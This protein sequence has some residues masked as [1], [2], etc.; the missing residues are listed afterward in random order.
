[1]KTRDVI[2]FE[3]VDYENEEGRHS[4]NFGQDGV[5]GNVG[6]VEA[7]N[8]RDQ[9]S[10]TR[11]EAQADESAISSLSTDT[12]ES[13]IYHPKYHGGEKSWDD[14]H[15]HGDLVYLVGKER[16]ERSHEEVSFSN[17]DAP[18]GPLAD[19]DG[20]D[21]IKEWRVGGSLQLRLA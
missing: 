4:S 9:E 8:Y 20:V 10:E 15:G 17:Q 7:R 18:N 14:D 6:V 3:M 1:M 21:K 12:P 13:V 16:G 2:I 11:E 19:I 5:R